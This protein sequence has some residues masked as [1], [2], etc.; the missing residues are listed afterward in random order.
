MSMDR[1]YIYALGGNSEYVINGIKYQVASRFLFPQ[2][3]Q[4]IL[5]KFENLIGSEFI[6]LTVIDNTDTIN[7]NVCSTAGKED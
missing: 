3:K 4:T 5:D 1:K 2:K 6:D 7:D